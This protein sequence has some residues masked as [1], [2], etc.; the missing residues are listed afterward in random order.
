MKV[1]KKIIAWAKRSDPDW[2]PHDVLVPGVLIVL[3]LAV[4]WGIEWAIEF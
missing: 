3:G 1:N 4:Y 2:S